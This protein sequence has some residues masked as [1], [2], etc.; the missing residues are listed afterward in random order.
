MPRHRLPTQDSPPMDAPRFA[1]L[2]QH[3][4]FSRRRALHAAGGGLSTLAGFGLRP[5]G[6]RSQPGPPGAR[7]SAPPGG[8]PVPTTG[9]PVPE[10]AVV[11][12]VMCDLMARWQLPGGQLALAKDRRLVLNRGYGLADVSYVP[13]RP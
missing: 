6:A 7:A 1:R 5:R 9:Q 13:P 12:A 4:A 3:P 2:G 10:P 11:D 8:T